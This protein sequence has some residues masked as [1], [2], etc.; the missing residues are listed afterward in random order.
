MPKRITYLDK[1]DRLSREDFRLHWSTTHAEIARDLPGV[2]AYRQNHVVPLP[3]LPASD[4]AYPVDGIVEL[5]FDDED[6]VQAAFDSDIADRLA[7]DELRFLSGLTG[8]AVSPAQPYEVW[9]HKLWLLARW[10]G[11]TDSGPEAVDGWAERLAETCAG[12]LGVSVNYLRADAELLT[13]KALRSDPHLP[14]IAVALGFASATTAAAAAARIAEGL[15]PL[16]GVLDRVHG[17]L[18]EEVVII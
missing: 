10:S 8:G 3:V 5:W 9:P 1:R 2:T 14:Q 4:D 17:Y 7:A 11:G 6:V 16:P 15:D 13:R 18:A 12:A